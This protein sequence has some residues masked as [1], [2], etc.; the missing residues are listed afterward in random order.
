MRVLFFFSLLCVIFLSCKT[1]RIPEKGNATV[2]EPELNYIPYYLT[3]YKAD[4]LFLIDDFKG[5]YR[6]LDSLFKIYPPLDTDNY[7]EYSIYLNSAVMSGNVEDV[8]AKVRYGYRHFGGIVALHKN[9]YEMHIAVDSAAKLTETD[10]AQLKKEYANSL[11]HGL[12]ERLRR[13]HYED[14]AIRLNGGSYEEMGLIDWKNR[15]I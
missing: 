13:M 3:M 10:I 1:K 11:D 6:L 9:N 7:V 5:S 8:E 15:S 12:R 4:S 2:V 14:Q